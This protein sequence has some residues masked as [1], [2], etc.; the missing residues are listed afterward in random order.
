MRGQTP[1]GLEF[2]AVLAGPAG[3]IFLT[4]DRKRSGWG[5]A[6]PLEKLSLLRSQEIHQEIIARE[7][8][9]GEPIEEELKQI[10]PES[11]G[12]S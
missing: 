3:W 10:K 1:V 2:S 6:N 8:V 12:D 9:F 5:G 7:A 11:L 4:E